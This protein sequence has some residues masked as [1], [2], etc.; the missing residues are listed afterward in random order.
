MLL[1]SDNP[2]PPLAAVHWG[3]EPHTFGLRSA[4]ADVLARAAVVLRPWLADSPE[5]T[6]SWTVA[7]GVEPNRWVL[8]SDAGLE[9]VIA[10]DSQRVITHVEFH[11][12]RALLDGPSHALTFHAALVARGNQG[13][14]IIGPNEAGKSTL[15]CELWRRGFSL[16]GDDVAIVESETAEA[17]SAPRRVSLRA[18]SRRL[19]GESLWTRILAAP[20]SEPTTDGY[21]FHPDEVDGRACPPAVRLAG[22]LFL[23]RRGAIQTE[24]LAGPLSSGQVV[25]LLMPYSNLIRQLDPG[26]VV[27]R[28]APLAA[29]VPAY[30][31]RRGPLPDMVTAVERLLDGRL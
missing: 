18:P 27:S 14:L 31:M 12:V 16:L 10:G 13:L 22:C 29:A 23:A 4:D 28:I 5:P 7:R 6:Y 15:A 8:R 21:V 9:T 11:A 1:Q 3:W 25:L 26:T 20:S 2:A 24:T 30:D 19:L 17:R